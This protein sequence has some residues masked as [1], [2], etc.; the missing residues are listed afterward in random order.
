MGIYRQSKPLSTLGKIGRIILKRFMYSQLAI[1][2]GLKIAIGKENP[3]V[4]FTVEKD[5]PSVYWVYRIK[6]SEVNNLARKIGLPSHFS[7]CPIQCLDGEE[8]EFWMTINAY[9]VSGLAK[10]L[11]AE[12]SVFVRDEENTPRYLIVDAR[13]STFSVDPIDI[14]TRASTVIHERRDKQLHTEIG[15]G[16]QAFTSTITITD[17][18]TPV[19]VSRDW[20]SANDYIYWGNGI[21]DRTFYDTGLAN[22]KQNR[23]RDENFEVKDGS[24]WSR[25]VEPAPAHVLL[26]Q[27]AIEFVISPW[28][29][30]DRINIR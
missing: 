5:P 20:V 22:T 10:G 25:F 30:I 23:V 8:P 13:S 1:L 29:N 26:L 17:I 19:T 6:S 21:C 28:E 3:L 24:F 2:S 14:I 7:L 4:K 9:R 15:E 11:R 16:D 27:N 18:A 12:W